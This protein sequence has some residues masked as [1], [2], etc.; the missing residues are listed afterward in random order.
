MY[1]DDSGWTVIVTAVDYGRRMAGIQTTTVGKTSTDPWG[2]SDDTGAFYHLF[3]GKP[4]KP[5]TVD[6]GK[7]R[8]V[9]VTFKGNKS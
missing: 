5:A 3:D 7:L 1:V 9:G 2:F 4:D 8:Q 6:F